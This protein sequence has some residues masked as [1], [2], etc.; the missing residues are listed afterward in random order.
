[1]TPDIRV[2]V[3][4]GVLDLA[5]ARPEKKNALTHAMYTAL[6][7]ALERARRDGSVR[8]VLIH[9]SDTCFTAG[10]DLR[11]FLDTPPTGFDSPVFRFIKGASVFEK[12]MV[13]AVEGA[14]VGIGTT[15]LLHADL[16]VAGDGST[17]QMPFVNLGVCPE[18]ASSLLLPRIMGHVRAARL[19]LL[20]DAFGAD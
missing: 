18:V 6:A 4:G 3:E 11:D 15:L 13:V 12:P 2:Q 10:N 5:I 20:C 19:L 1:V 14:A 7:D 17:F 9:G 8:V 16:A